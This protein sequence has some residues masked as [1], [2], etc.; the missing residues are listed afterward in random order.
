MPKSKVIL[1]MHTEEKEWLEQTV[2]Q[3]GE[4]KIGLIR[5]LL[6]EYALKMGFPPRPEK[7]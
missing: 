5:S 4:T 6:D 3:P 7:K 1:D 2:L